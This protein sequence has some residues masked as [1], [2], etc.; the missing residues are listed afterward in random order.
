MPAQSFEV[1]ILEI[2]SKNKPLFEAE[3]ISISPAS[4]EKQM[5][6]AFWAGFRYA[7]YLKENAAPEGDSNIFDSLFGKGFGKK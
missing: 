7:E 5:S 4:L 3:K 2:K 6:S 1:W